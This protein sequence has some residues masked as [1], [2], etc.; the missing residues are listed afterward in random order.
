V[1]PEALHGLEIL[2]RNRPCGMQLVLSSRCDPPLSL[3]RLRLAGRLW[4]LRAAQMRF[5]PAEATELY[6]RSGLH[7]TSAQVGLLHRRTGGWA[8]GLRLAALGL[9]ASA[10]PDEF[11]SQFS[12]DERSVADYL[13]GE[14]LAGLPED[15]QEFLRVISISEPIPS[16]L[17]TELSGRQDAGSV[18]TTLERQTALV[19]STPP[20]RDT[21]CIQ[22]LLRTNLL[23][24]LRRHGPNRVAELHVVA[25][26]WWADRHA[27]RA[28][29]HA[30][31]SHDRGLLTELLHRFGVSLILSG[32]HAP[33]RRALVCAGA[34]AVA[35]DP[36]LALTSA[37]VHVEAGQLPAAR[38]DIH[39][40]RQPAPPTW[41]WPC[42]GPWPSSSAPGARIP[43]A[44]RPRSPLRRSTSC[45]PNPSWRRSP[46][47]DTPALS[48][49]GAIWSG[50]ARSSRSR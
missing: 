46:V 45:P 48:S 13:V 31:Q 17:A 49:A 22:E 2:I 30:M 12:G 34:H 26:Q 29:E 11:L 23:A 8:A 4:E 36:W 41:T 16:G 14:V 40:A 3:P 47:S 10:D 21:Y 50:P 27:T 1:E 35:T 39:H 33:L 37:L 44:H 20:Q 24:D 43:P 19:S 5:S 7:L 25:A 42:C 18:L 38:A 28:L 15:V 6:E 9:A 32:H